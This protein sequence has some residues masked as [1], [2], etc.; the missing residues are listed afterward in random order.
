MAVTGGAPCS[1]QLHREMLNVLGVK[2]IRNIFGLTETTAAAFQSRP[3]DTIEQILY[4]VG[5]LQDNIEAK[6][7]DSEGNVLPF[8]EPGELCIRGYSTFLGYY[9]DAVKTAD[10]IGPDKWLRTG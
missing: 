4:T 7:I 6:I 1:P 10:T 5:H 9:N 3:G 2:E 8:G